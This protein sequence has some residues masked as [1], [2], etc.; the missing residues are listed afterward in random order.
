VMLMN[1]DNDKGGNS[2]EVFDVGVDN[3]DGVLLV[4]RFNSAV[5]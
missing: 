5:N 4:H 3:I 1:D 2:I